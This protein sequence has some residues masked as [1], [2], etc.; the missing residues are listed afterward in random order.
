MA[1]IVRASTIA[2]QKN[3]RETRAAAESLKKILNLKK[4]SIGVPV[5][6]FRLQVS[7]SQTF[8]EVVFDKIYDVDDDMDLKGAG[9]PE[10]A[11]WVRAAAI[12][13]LGAQGK[14]EPPEPYDIR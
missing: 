10:G 14:F 5:A 6:A 13:L 12:D 8:D 7:Q 4:L 2:V 1:P 3:A 11:Y 9:L